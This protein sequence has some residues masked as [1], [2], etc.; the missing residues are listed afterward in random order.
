MPHEAGAYPEL[1]TSAMN[2]FLVGFSTAR[3]D[4][5]LLITDKFGPY[6]V[7]EKERANPSCRFITRERLQAFVDSIALTQ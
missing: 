4:R 7:Y 1:E 5:G 3:T 6:S 2:Q